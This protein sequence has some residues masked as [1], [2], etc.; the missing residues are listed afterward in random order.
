MDEVVLAISEIAAI[1]FIVKM[2]DSKNDDGF[3]FPN[4]A[5]DVSST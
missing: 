5:D 4:L 2:E 1:R 3:F